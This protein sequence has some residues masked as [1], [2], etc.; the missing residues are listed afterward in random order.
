MDRTLA[1]DIVLKFEIQAGY[2][3]LYD[4]APEGQYFNSFESLKSHNPTL[5]AWE[6]YAACSNPEFNTLSECE[7]SGEDF[8]GLYGLPV[9]LDDDNQFVVSD[10][11]LSDFIFHTDFPG[12]L[13]KDGLTDNANIVDCNIDAERCGD[14]V[15]A[16]TCNAFHYCS[17][18][19]DENLCKGYD[20]NEDGLEDS[21]NY[22]CCQPAYQ[23]SDDCNEDH[24]QTYYDSDCPEYVLYPQ[25]LD[26]LDGKSVNYIDGNTSDNWTDAIGGTRFFFTNGY[27][28]F[29]ETTIDGKNTA[30]LQEF[31]TVEKDGV[32]NGNQMMAT[33]IEE[34]LIFG[35]LEMGGLFAAL[36]IFD[37]KFELYYQGGVEDFF[38]LRPPYEYMIE[39]SDVP[40]YK[41]DSMDNSDVCT[42]ESEAVP[43][44]E[45]SRLPFRVKNLT[46]DTWVKMRHADNDLIAGL[47]ADELVD[48]DGARDCF[49]S[50]SEI[51]SLTDCVRTYEDPSLQL[52]GQT[53]L[54]EEPD[55]SYDL[56]LNY[57]MFDFFNA[58]NSEW[59]EGIEYYKGDQVFFQSMTWEASSNVP[60]DMPPPS[61][62]YLD[63]D[64]NTIRRGFYDFGK[65]LKYDEQEPGEGSDP[66]GDNWHITDNP[67]GTEGDGFNDNPWKPVYPWRGPH[68]SSDESYENE[69]DCVSAGEDW[70]AGDRLYFSPIAWYTDGDSWTVDMGEVAMELDD[71]PLFSETRVVPNP[72]RAGSTYSNNELHF[73]G[74][75]SSCVI[76]IY[77]VTGKLIDTIIRTE[78]IDGLEEWDL[79]NYNGDKI[80]PGLYIYHINSNGDEFIGKF[81]VVR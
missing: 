13:C 61:G 60:S 45:R 8:N 72:Y 75:P 10:L 49:W 59:K 37:E 28:S 19:S 73:E 76:K 7:D 53:E 22:R 79:T 35:D 31:T 69:I 23:D 77:T 63:S 54:G 34:D 27:E 57:F 71:V 26:G 55:Y 70:H 29:Q 68:C 62:S 41:A 3:P 30:Q 18:D 80:A 39:F 32:Y 36:T 56:N 14:L 4:N 2:T 51:I 81:A 40:E 25:Y 20:D 15:D 6:V 9:Y 44:E 74:L 42:Y 58:Y 12:V 52:L 21:P 48:A 17:W 78:E 46:T 67:D 11:T 5:Y 43:L 64:G 1:E 50:R 66:S 65:D 47:G 38:K 24:N 16:T 33:A